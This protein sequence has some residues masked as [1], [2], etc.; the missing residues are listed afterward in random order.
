MFWLRNKKIISNPLLSGG[1][2]YTTQYNFVSG[3]SHLISVR[4][5]AVLKDARLQKPE[6]LNVLVC[7]DSNF[8]VMACLVSVCRLLLSSRPDMTEKCWMGRKNQIIPKT[9]VLRLR[10]I[11]WYKLVSVCAETNSIPWH[12]L[13]WLK[14]FHIDRN[15]KN[16]KWVWSGN[17]TITNC[18]Q[19]R[20]TARKSRSTITRHQQDKL[21]KAISSLFPIK[22]I[23]ILEWT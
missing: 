9:L 16:S 20:G 1:M 14:Q 19:P 4:D 10:E 7:R 23:A 5:E 22:M 21:S 3:L 8:K 11:L 12:M 6:R 2:N 13:Q 15:I 17:T 18:R